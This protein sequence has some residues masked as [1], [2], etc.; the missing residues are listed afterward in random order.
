VKALQV[1]A[2]TLIEDK[3]PISAR[4]LNVQVS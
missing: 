4:T 3:L 1:I 2:T